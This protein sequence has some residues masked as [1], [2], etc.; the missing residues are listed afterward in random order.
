MPIALGVGIGVNA[1]RGG[2]FSFD[3][4][5]LRGTLDRTFLGNPSL[6]TFGPDGTTPPVE[7]QG[8]SL[9][10]DAFEG[11]E[12]GSE[13]VTGAATLPTGWSGD[14]NTGPWV[15]TAGTANSATWSVG[16]LTN[17]RVYVIEFEASVVSAST[18]TPR[19][20]GG[21]T[22]TGVARSAAG[23]YRQLVLATAAH[24]TLDIQATATT[25]G[26]ITRVSVRE[27][28][29]MP[30]FQNT[31]ANQ[32]LW[33][34]APKVVRNLMPNSGLEGAAAGTPGTLPTGYT[35][36]VSGGQFSSVDADGLLGGNSITMEVSDGRHFIE[37]ANA[38]VASANTDYVFS[39]RCNIEFGTLEVRRLIGSLGT[40]Y[41]TGTTFT[42]KVDGDVVDG[43]FEVPVGDHIIEIVYGVVATA[44]NISPRA[45]LGII[46]GS[47]TGKISINSPQFELGTSRTDYQRTSPDRN[48]ITEAGVPSL[49]YLVASGNRAMDFRSVEG[50]TCSV[51]IPGR[52]GCYYLPSSTIA[53]NTTLTAGA[54]NLT[55]APGVP[56]GIMQ[57]VGNV[58]YRAT[59]ERALCSPVVL[60]K[61]NLTTDELNRLLRYYQRALGAGGLLELGSD[62]IVNGVF[63]ADTDWTKGTGWTIGSGVATKTAGSAGALEQAQTIAVG[64]VW[65]LT[66]EVTRTAGTLTPRFVNS[67]GTVRFT[68]QGITAS[69]AI[70]QVM[71]DG[72]FADI[73]RFQFNADATF[74]GT[75]DNVTLRP[76]NPAA[77]L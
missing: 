73:A 9:M 5:D 1:R 76:F 61:P 75:V 14:V 31:A 51:F 36:P 30:G 56:L 11:I 15:K 24:T 7:A 64:S 66:A 23:V 17:N 60:L 72:N 4:S 38:I 18:F 57:A 77:L 37:Y 68:G 46:S 2:A 69:G 25:A 44:G 63:A 49:P 59:T 33:A 52:R 43:T 13:R 35:F 74:A 71:T 65:L 48:T 10:G 58:P 27:V 54:L 53:A 50:D 26:T 70:A 42:Y 55:N 6:F 20:T 40:G 19:L 34:S 45:G 16:T 47:V 8:V 3:P 67:G 32:M 12:T 28:L 21:A 41:P 39:F 29:N 22:V 62:V